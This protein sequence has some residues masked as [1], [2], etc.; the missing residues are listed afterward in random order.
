MVNVSFPQS[1]PQTS[2]PRANKVL[3]SVST[4]SWLWA[5][6]FC[7]PDFWDSGSASCELHELAKGTTSL[8]AIPS[9]KISSHIPTFHKMFANH[10]YLDV[11]LLPQIEKQTPTHS[12]PP[13]PHL[14]PA[15]QV[16]CVGLYLCL[17]NQQ[18]PKN[19][20]KSPYHPCLRC[21]WLFLCQLS[22]LQF[23]P[24]YP[25]TW[26]SSKT[27]FIP[28]TQKEFFL[29]HFDQNKLHCHLHQWWDTMHE[30]LIETNSLCSAWY[31]PSSEFSFLSSNIFSQTISC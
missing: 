19:I 7:R 3:Q 1:K 16:F 24:S 27:A 30:L 23:T 12:P 6:G 20:S 13:P 10:L 17:G 21:C 25:S 5:V 11:S 2:G 31:P 4:C 9:F 8:H 15:P 22:A 18:L 29:T 26:Y 28:Q 14:A